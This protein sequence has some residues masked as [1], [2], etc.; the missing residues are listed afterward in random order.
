M[1]PFVKGGGRR[2]EREE[3]REE[4]INDGEERERVHDAFVCVCVRARTLHTLSH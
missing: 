1:L 4:S 2:G 3:D